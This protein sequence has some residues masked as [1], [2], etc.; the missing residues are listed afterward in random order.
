M[1]K[2]KLAPTK[3][4]PNPSTIKSIIENAYKMGGVLYATVPLTQMSV[5]FDYQRPLC[6][7]ANIRA[8]WDIRK[9][10]PLLL[11]YR[12]GKL[13]VVDGDNRREAAFG[14]V[15]SLPCKI[16]TG[17]TK[18]EEAFYFAH[19]ND[20]VV[21]LSTIDKFLALLVSG[22]PA[23]HLL[24]NICEKRNIAI[25]YAAATTTGVLRA[26]SRS[27]EIINAGEV[28]ALEW[29]FDVIQSGGWHNVR[30]G[31]GDRLIAALYNLRMK[32]ADEA[33][34][35]FGAVAGFMLNETPESF[36]AKARLEFMGYGTISAMTSYL[37]KQ[38][39]MG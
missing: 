15:D 22:D 20:N 8:N 33:D 35:L 36:E 7:Y 38:I 16:L 31:Y 21:K 25:K 13:W 26:L 39:K 1:R 6:S 9:C 2:T 18:T 24:K 23:A 29:C 32:Y 19:Q 12:D 28:K 5:D 37:D 10:D 34:V 27:L 11:S 4:N 14:L 17:L 30:G 3:S